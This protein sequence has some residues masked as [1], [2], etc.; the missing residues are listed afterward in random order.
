M[1]TVKTIGLDRYAYAHKLPT[2]GTAH[3]GRG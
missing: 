2:F 3:P 1:K